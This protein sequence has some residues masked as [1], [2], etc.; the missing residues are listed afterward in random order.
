[1]QAAS[2]ETVTINMK[3]STK[4]FVHEFYLFFEHSVPTGHTLSSQCSLHRWFPQGFHVTKKPFC[5][6]E[7]RLVAILSHFGMEQ[8]LT[9]KLV[10]LRFKAG[11]SVFLTS[12]EPFSYFFTGVF[13]LG[14]FLPG[15]DIFDV[16]EISCSYLD[17]RLWLKT[18][19]DGL[20]VR[21]FLLVLVFWLC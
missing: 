17:D 1:M 14:L 9:S 4:F 19:F 2:P 10:I 11:L 21:W 12:D 13:F 18:F 6:F 16:S 20:L 5:C 7:H 3:S 15:L 8:V